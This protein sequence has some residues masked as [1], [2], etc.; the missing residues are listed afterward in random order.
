[1]L[2]LRGSEAFLVKRI[3]IPQLTQILS[4]TKNVYSNVAFSIVLTLH[5][6]FNPSYIPDTDISLKFTKQKNGEF[7]E[8][9]YE[10]HFSDDDDNNTIVIIKPF[11]FGDFW[12]HIYVEKQ[13]IMSS[14]LQISIAPSPSEEVLLLKLDE[15]KNLEN[16]IKDKR[17]ERAQRRQEEKIKACEDREEKMERTRKRAQDALKHYLEKK[18]ADLIAKEIEHERKLKAKTGGGYVIPY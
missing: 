12:I 17:L 10:L 15:L 13:E 5:D 16:L 8:I 14:P 11:G 1:M 2:S 4:F 6:Q 9:D 3:A 7:D 18:E